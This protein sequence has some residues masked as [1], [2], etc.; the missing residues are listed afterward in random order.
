MPLNSFNERRL[1]RQRLKME[2][3]I[4]GPQNRTSGYLLDINE[5]GIQVKMVKNIQLDEGDL[6]RI[7]TKSG[8]NLFG[9]IV[10]QRRDL[11]GVALELSSNS[12]AQTMGIVRAAQSGQTATARS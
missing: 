5:R 9:N 8:E 10:W 1:K 4:E 12:Y 7:I 3:I 2:C 6:V 11:A